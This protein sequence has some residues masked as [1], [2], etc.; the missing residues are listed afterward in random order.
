MK[1]FM[2][3]NDIQMVKGKLFNWELKPV[4]AIDN[5]K[6]H[7][8]I[9]FHSDGDFYGCSWME[10]RLTISNMA[11]SSD[12]TLPFECDLELAETIVMSFAKANKFEIMPLH[13]KEK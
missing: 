8:F 5:D 4:Y 11:Y 10:N 9:G 6:F 2:S 3:P 13:K 12:C 1:K 7:H